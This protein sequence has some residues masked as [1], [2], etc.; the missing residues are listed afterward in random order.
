MRVQAPP[1]SGHKKRRPP[2][3]RDAAIF[4]FAINSTLGGPAAHVDMQQALAPLLLKLDGPG[5]M[6]ARVH[7]SLCPAVA[8]TNFPV[9]SRIIR[10]WLSR[11]FF[12]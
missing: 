6:S 4:P 12:F 3:C 5:A 2:K 9:F 8:Q 1:A 10:R 11:F 7:S